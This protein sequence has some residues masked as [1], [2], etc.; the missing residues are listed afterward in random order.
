MTTAKLFNQ[1]GRKFDK[2]EVCFREEKGV[3]MKRTKLWP[4]GAGYGL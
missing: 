4:F 1:E 2:N 3:V